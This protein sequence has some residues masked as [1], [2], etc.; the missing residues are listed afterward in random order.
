MDDSSKENRGE[1]LAGKSGAV[2]AGGGRRRF[3]ILAGGALGT[4]ALAGA[5]L[6]VADTG[7]PEIVFA[8][9]TF[10]EANTMGDRILVAYASEHGSTSGVADALGKQLAVGGAAVDVRP[11]KEVTDLGPYRAVVVGSAVHGGKWLPEALSFVRANQSKL[12]QMP[13][14]YFLVGMMIAKDAEKHRDMSAAA[15]DPARQ[16]VNPVAEGMFGGAVRFGNYSLV[17]GLGM[18]VFLATISM[19]EGDYRDWNAIRAW[20]DGIRPLLG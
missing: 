17:K 14:A 13:T 18:R 3:L 5:G 9:S 10:G 4:A 16:L 7:E 8:K 1:E 11:V 15:F 2:R 6:T 12:G 19:P 20:A